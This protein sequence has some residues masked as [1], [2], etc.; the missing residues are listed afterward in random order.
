MDELEFAGKILQL[1]RLRHILKKAYSKRIS[2]I[3]P[4]GYV[5]DFRILLKE[6]LETYPNK[7]LEEFLKELNDNHWIVAAKIIA[8]NETIENILDYAINEIKFALRNRE[9]DEI[10]MEINTINLG[11]NEPELREQFL[12][13]WE[14]IQRIVFVLRHSEIDINYEKKRKL[15]QRIADLSMDLSKKLLD[16]VKDK[17]FRHLIIHTFIDWIVTESLH[18]NCKIELPE[19]CRLS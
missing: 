11:V 8:E 12:K 9:I 5:Q 2:K 14:K 7:E 19:T 18:Y 6:V 13:I 1:I 17:D 15:M 16:R 3:P 4:L 10:E